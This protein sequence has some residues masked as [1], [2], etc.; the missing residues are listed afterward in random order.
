MVVNPANQGPLVPRATQDFQEHRVS[1]VP[2]DR[3]EVQVS[4]VHLVFQA[5][6]E[7]Q[8]FQDKVD[9]QVKFISHERT[10][11]KYNKIL[12]TFQI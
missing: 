12:R 9:N 7:I 3:R 5:P 8:A 2:P 1:L 6:K 4:L 11:Q 10:L